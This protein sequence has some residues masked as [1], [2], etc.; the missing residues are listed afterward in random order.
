MRRL[1]F[2][3]CSLAVLTAA[4]PAFGGAVY[5]PFAADNTTVGGITYETQV[6][7]SNRGS[8]GRRFETF[9]IPAGVNGT[10]R[11][12]ATYGDVGIG[13]GA[14]AVVTGVAPEGE[15]GMLEINGAPQVI[16]SARIVPVAGQNGRLGADLPV[17]S[18]ETLLGAN[19]TVHLQGLARDT[20]QTTSF[21]LT[22]A[23]Q[24]AA[25]CNVSSFLAN[26]NALAN[27]AQLSLPPL[28][29]FHVAD[30]LSALGAQ[31]V[32]GARFTVTC[33][34][35]FYAYAITFDSRNAGVNVIRPGELLTSTLAKPGVTPPPPSCDGGAVCL[36]K[37]GVFFTPTRGEDYRRESLPIPAGV[38]SRVELDVTVQING[39]TSPS[40]G[41]HMFFW[42]ALNRNFDLL[43][44]TALRGPGT[45]AILFRHGVGLG[46]TEKAKIVIPF[47]P[48]DGS[49]YTANYIW[50]A[51]NRLITLRILDGSGNV[52]ETI[53]D[54]TNVG[55]L[56]VNGSNE[57]LVA[58]FSFELGLNSNEPPQYNWNYSNLSV[59]AYPA[60]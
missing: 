14:S 17:I 10:E 35:Q 44:F 27:P 6:W 47:V 21:I 8:A 59:R 15:I 52:L 11:A 13:A 4:V 12:D 25:S 20:Q 5:V 30:A 56:Q 31:A 28:S 42:L 37:Q 9:F 33:D 53:T 19:A 41:L 18:S 7:A 49:T 29:I 45:N 26:G 46:A 54:R 60:P 50:D 36:E 24:V 43:G 32:N 48:Q 2:L 22:N 34:R 58:D 57:N 16:I 40:G 23:S 38:Y 3:V 51:G 1:A 55:R 39:W